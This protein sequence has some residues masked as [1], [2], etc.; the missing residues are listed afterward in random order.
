VSYPARTS[1]IE[2]DDGDEDMHLHVAQER[3]GYVCLRQGLDHI[4]MPRA[5]ARGLLAELAAFL[6]KP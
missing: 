5:H 6:V 4:H 1:R 3:D 2:N